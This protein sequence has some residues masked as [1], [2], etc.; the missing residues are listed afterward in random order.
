MSTSLTKLVR[1]F[2]V[3]CAVGSNAFGCG[4]EGDDGGGPGPRAPS[5][6]KAEA[7]ATNP[8]AV[9]LTWND[10]AGDEKNFVVERKVGS[11]EFTALEMKEPD[12]KVHHDGTV[13]AG[14]TYTYRVAA[15]NDKGKNYSAE[16]TAM[17]K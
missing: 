2:L 14:M 16:V 8:P 4:G 11:G 15:V 1:T 9:H 5:N 17:V 7:L 10:N 13:Q 6:L 12:I 3:V